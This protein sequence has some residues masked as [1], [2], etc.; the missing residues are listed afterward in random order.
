MNFKKIDVLLGMK[1][2]KRLPNTPHL[3]GY[4]L[5]EHCYTVAMLFRWF[6]SEED[7]PYD[8]V[9]FD[10]VLMHDYVESV[11][12]DLNALIKKFNEKTDK[13]WEVIENEICDSDPILREYSDKSIKECMTELQYRLFKT[14]DYLELWIFCRKEQALGNNTKG[15]RTCVENCE[16]FMAKYSDNWKYFDSIIKFMRQYEA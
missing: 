15:I 8:M 4:N 14:C 7:V 6:A 10:R 5:L 12:G 16:K 11:T 2:I 9:V 3:Q 1:E 13:A